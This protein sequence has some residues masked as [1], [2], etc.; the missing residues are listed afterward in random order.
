MR[1]AL[2]K[3]K[4]QFKRA[5]RRIFDKAARIRRWKNFSKQ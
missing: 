5:M 1:P 3:Y 2:M 4:F